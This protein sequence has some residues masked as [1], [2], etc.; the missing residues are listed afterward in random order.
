MK[1]NNTQEA[2]TAWFSVSLGVPSAYSHRCLHHVFSQ[3]LGSPEHQD[4]FLDPC[5]SSAVAG[6]QGATLKAAVSPGEAR[7]SW[8]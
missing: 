6:C 1:E 7:R 2:R 4:V 5:S 3:I 8:F